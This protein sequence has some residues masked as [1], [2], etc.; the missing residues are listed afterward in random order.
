MA[1]STTQDLEWLNIF[2]VYNNNYYD[3]HNQDTKDYYTMEEQTKYILNQIRFS[4]FN[5]HVK[6]IFIEAEIKN[7]KERPM[8]TISF[9]YKKVGTWLSAVDRVWR[10]EESI[11]IL[12][13]E[14]SLEEILQRLKEHY[15]AK[16]HM[17]ITVGHGSI[18]GI[19]YYIPE[20]KQKSSRGSND[21]VESIFKKRSGIISSVKF[22]KELMTDISLESGKR[23]LYLTNQEISNAL[24]KVFSDK[25]V[26]VL[27][28]YN[29]LMQNIFTQFD[30]RETVEW[31]IAPLSGISIPGFNYTDI[32]DE[33][34]RDPFLTGDKVAAL[35]I[36]T[37]RTGN[38]YLYYKNDIESTW[39]IAAL[40][41]NKQSL[42]LIQQNFNLFIKR[43]NEISQASILAQESDDVINCINETLRHLFNYGA[44]C[45]PSL[46]IPDLGILL[47]VLKTNITNDYPNL[48]PLC[49][50]INNLQQAL[51]T[52]TDKL[53]FE[54]KDFYNNGI[55][56]K[57]N[58]AVLKESV[59]DVGILF[60][61]RQFDSELLGFIFKRNQAGS[62]ADAN[63]F[64]MPSFL[65]NE[66][67]YATV[68]NKILNLPQ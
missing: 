9:L 3:L 34:N 13:N 36:N 21:D 45:L 64:S 7:Y 56:H 32:L 29:C 53:I 35:F 66:S 61:F 17:V 41:M 31:L 18:V 28:M 50:N 62:Q 8:A 1:A 42:E 4:S 30:F 2:L 11:D 27:A 15:P 23:L 5:E 52:Q 43:V 37:I 51:K 67:D 26:D 68:I 54:G 44:Y 47:E 65:A 12:T 58:D 24:N 60:P 33:I 38:R 6:T 46:D 39:K 48:L 22:Q 19:N 14:K 55:P 40:K 25:K 59:A 20:L 16:K 10:D 57:E 63:E 49:E